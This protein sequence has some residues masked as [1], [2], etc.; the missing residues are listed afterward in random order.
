MKIVLSEIPDEGLDLSEEE[1]IESDEVKTVS[2][3]C[4]KLRVEK[5]GSEV[6]IK[7][8]IMA[9]VEL[10]C[11]RCLRD[12]RQELTVPF[13]VVY[14]SADELNADERYQLKPSELETGFYRGDELDTGELF[15]EQLLLNCPIKPLCSD[16]C[17]G[18]CPQCGVDLNEGICKCRHQA[19]DVRL[20]ALKKYFE[21]R[22]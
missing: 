15:K 11:S 19:S 3:A 21:R 5:I 12:F 16:S 7:G 13:D 1:S 10:V 20:E 2:P 9:G 22:Q 17:K 18:I 14:H 8:S 6:I 4:F